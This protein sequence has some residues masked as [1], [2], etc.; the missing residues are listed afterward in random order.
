MRIGMNCRILSKSTPAGTARYARQLLA[1]SLDTSDLGSESTFS[2][3]GLGDPPHQFRDDDR[4]RV[5]DATPPVPSG[6]C[7]YVWEQLCLPRVIQQTDIDVFHT[8]AGIPP[9]LT[10]V[11]QVTT[12]HDL[13]PITHPE[14]FAKKYATFYQLLVPFAVRFS[15]RIIAV[16]DFTREEIVDHYPSAADKTVTVHN[17]V[18]PPDIDGVE[19]VTPLEGRDFLLS[20]G[21][22]NPR[23]NLRRLVE[24]YGILRR[25]RPDS[26]ELVLAG[27][28]NDI[29]DATD[30][31]SV[32]GVRTLGFVP[33]EQL[34]WLYKQTDA[35][36]YPSLYEGFGLPILEAMSVGTP[37]VTSNRGAMA[38]VAGDA[39][40]L[41][42]P[43]D[44]ESIAAGILEALADPE[45]AETLRVAGRDRAA[46]FGWEQTAMETIQVY[47]EAIE[48]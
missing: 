21:A 20:V 13:S 11:P 24:A 27:P 43:E 4:M 33:D 31:P 10:R 2:L 32:S 19:A 48:S 9:L 18:V 41:V 14:W 36:V 5:S 6:L 7:A 23:K 35:L 47:H 1:A 8:P 29:F 17:G 42:D 39:A 25:R 22:Q 40:L 46:E 3:F 16:S 38:E 12:I 45:V 30:I 34:A 15:D 26:P 28:S 44:S 37:V